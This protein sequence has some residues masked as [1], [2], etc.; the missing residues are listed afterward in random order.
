MASE[1]I[2][3]F[4][5]HFAPLRSRFLEEIKLKDETEGW[6][7]E[8]QKHL[9]G[10]GRPW[11]KKIPDITLTSS[12]G[13]CMVLIEVKIN[14]GPTLDEE[15]RPQTWAYSEYLR[16]EKQKGVA[17]TRLIAL[18][19]WRPDTSFGQ[20]CD[21]I[22]DFNKLLAWINESVDG[23]PSD[24]VLSRMMFEW[25]EYIKNQRWIM[26]PI[27]QEHLEA[28]PKITDLVIQL[29]EVLNAARQALIEGEDKWQ[30]KKGRSS[31][32]QSPLRERK[33][34]FTWTKPIGKEDTGGDYHVQ[35]GCFYG[36]EDRKIVIRPVISVPEPYLD[37]ISPEVASKWEPS[38]WSKHVK[39]I[40]LKD[41]APDVGR[42]NEVWECMRKDISR[43]L[44]LMK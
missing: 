22:F 30:E 3:F 38:W 10:P 8:T 28:I 33:G 19:R 26:K 41:V 15:G 17:E 9:Y 29:T 12:N 5:E 11:D 42:N 24:P 20:H 2:A 34:E 1:I 14:A 7:V 27:T 37:R 25:G 21:H 44:K 35:L 13:R 6:I 23:S 4:L 18:T 43:A 31:G 36:E 16:N 40:W 39:L 32:G